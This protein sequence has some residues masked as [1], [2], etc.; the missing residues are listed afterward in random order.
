MKS[1]RTARAP[2]AGTRSMKN[3]VLIVLLAAA[4]AALVVSHLRLPYAVR[5]WRM[6]E[7]AAAARTGERMT[8]AAPQGD[9]DVNSANMDEL[10]A[11]YGVGPAL[12]Q[13]I[14]A[15]REMNGA[16]HYPEDLLNVKGIGE[17]TLE[18]MWE[19]L[20]LP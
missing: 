6:E 1:A 11:L 2:L 5:T 9:V 17:K 15:E 20:K 3:K 4:A 13:E 12:A 18:K 16:F 7:S 10:Q 14:I 8:Y 19:Q